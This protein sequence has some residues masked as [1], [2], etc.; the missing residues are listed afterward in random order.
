MLRSRAVVVALAATSLAALTL[1]GCS[2]DDGPEDD[3]GGETPTV[4]EPPP[5]DA[6]PDGCTL[7]PAELIRETLGI[8]AGKGA[9]QT[10]AVGGPDSCEYGVILGSVQIS[11]DADTFFAGE[12]YEPD[13]VPDAVDAP[14]PADRGYVAVGGFLVV[15]GDTGVLFTAGDPRDSTL[16]QWTALA[17]EV[18]GQLP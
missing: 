10:S 2:G 8:D 12:V 17:T 16:E 14:E 6:L 3:G 15:R 5:S 11:T 18:A 1:S 7:I 4:A 9:A 13:A